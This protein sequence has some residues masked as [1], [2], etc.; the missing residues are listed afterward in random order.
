[1]QAS[2]QHMVVS[3]IPSGSVYTQK[4]LATVTDA[5]TEAPLLYDAFSALPIPCDGCGYCKAHPA[6]KH[7][8][9]DRFFEAFSAADHI[10]FAFPV[11]NN[12]VPAP[13][14]ALLDR[15]Q[16]FYYARFVRGERPPMPGRRTVTLVMTMGADHDVT[17]LILEQLRPI[18][19]ICGC[20]LRKSIVQV[21][22][23]RLS[24][25]DS[26]TPILKTYE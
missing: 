6:C 23:D 1:M 20:R 2:H 19:T 14:K 21:G 9:L 4:L 17:P 24:S 11:Y 13:L 16:Q 12:S 8:D 7:R 22:T 26:L 15:F 3:G 10:I 5:L 25:A 18:F